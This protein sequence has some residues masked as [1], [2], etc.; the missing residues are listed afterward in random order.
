MTPPNPST[1]VNNVTDKLN[2]DWFLVAALGSIVASLVLHQMDKKDEA[3]F[4][5]H[6]A[7]T[8]LAFGLYSKLLKMGGKE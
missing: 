2:S 8:F 5:G 3:N 7:P 1:A 6:W 4:V